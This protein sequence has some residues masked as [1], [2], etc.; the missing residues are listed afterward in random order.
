MKATI[1]YLSRDTEKEV[2][3]DNFKNLYIY[4]TMVEIRAANEDGI[5][6]SVKVPKDN[7]ISVNIVK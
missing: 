4:E 3:V 5:E 6:N 1:K 7:F 2:S